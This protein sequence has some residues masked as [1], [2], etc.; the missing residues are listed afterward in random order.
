LH[1]QKPHL[2]CSGA[3]IVSQTAKKSPLFNNNNY[4]YYLGSTAKAGFSNPIKWRI[5]DSSSGNY[6]CQL[7]L[8][9]PLDVLK[10]DVSETQKKIQKIIKIKIIII[11]HYLFIYIFI[12]LLVITRVPRKL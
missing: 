11:N 2:N 6:F 3:F 5:L 12:Y 4:Y 8:K 1:A 9:L 7:S 10:R